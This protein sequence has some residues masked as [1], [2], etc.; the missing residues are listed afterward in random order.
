VQKATYNK[1]TL[2]IS[3]ILAIHFGV[4]YDFASL[5]GDVPV[6]LDIEFSVEILVHF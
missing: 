5:A 2:S 6:M 3:C 4:G 1:I